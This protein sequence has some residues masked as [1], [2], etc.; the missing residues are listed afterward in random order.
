MKSFDVRILRDKDFDAWDAFVYSTVNGSIFSTA[1]YLDVL[2]RS[3]GDSYKVAAIDRDGAFIGGVALYAHKG[4]WG[5]VSGP[6]FLLP[7]TGLVYTVG[8][9]KYPS[10]SESLELKLHTALAE[11]IEQQDLASVMIKCRAPVKDIRVFMERGW[12]TVPT[13]TY[14]IDFTDLDAQWS[15]IDRNLRRLIKRCDA[16]D[17]VLTEDDDFD[18]FFALHLQ[19]HERKGAPLYLPADSFRQYFMALHEKGLARLFHARTADGQAVA[20]QIVLAGRHS[21]THTVA[22]GSDDKYIKTGVNALLRWKTFETLSRDGFCFN[23]LTD[24]SLNSVSRFKSQLGGELQMSF[25]VGPPPALL[26][27]VGSR[28]EKVAREFKGRIAGG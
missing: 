14:V 7:Y 4:R 15:R 18:A 12:R 16:G 10:R 26:Y 11:F 13:Y 27:R 8:D 25:A 6:R 23:D 22:A 1:E 5:Q 9:S 24:A 3:T 17:F 20:S 21:L 19:V 2:C 28:V